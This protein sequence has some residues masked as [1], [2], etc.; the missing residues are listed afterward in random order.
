[1]P[2]EPGRGPAP[3]GAGGAATI[4]RAEARAIAVA[5]QGFDRARPI[6]PPGADEIV[7]LVQRIGALQLDSINALCRSHYLPVFARLEPYDRSILDGLAAHGAEPDVR[8]F[9]EYGYYVL[10]FL[11]GDLL[12]ARV[13]LKADRAGGQLLVQGAFREPGCDIDEVEPALGRRLPAR[14]PPVRRSTSAAS[15]ARSS[16]SA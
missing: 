10:P 14:S 7:A 3:P 13:D 5:A 16:G 9:G 11:L 6:E 8:R 2:A 1:V 12:V 15:P 4:R